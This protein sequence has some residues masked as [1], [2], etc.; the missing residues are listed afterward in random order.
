MAAGWMDARS[1]DADVLDVLDV[2]E[3]LEVLM[4]ESAA[5]CPAG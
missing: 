3:V 1:R 5:C 2:L 4:D